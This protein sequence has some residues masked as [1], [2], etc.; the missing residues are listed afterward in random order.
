V[1]PVGLVIVHD[2]DP[3]GIG[4]AT[5]APATKTVRVVVPPRIGELEAE[6]AIVG[7]R[8]EIP[9][10]TEFEVAAV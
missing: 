2:I 10:V 7:T 5:E 4:L 6:R 3:A 8:V 1:D 9:N